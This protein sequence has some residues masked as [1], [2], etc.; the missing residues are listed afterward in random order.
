MS[1]WEAFS[2][3]ASAIEP[4]LKRTLT[5]SSTRSPLPSLNR[6]SEPRNPRFGISPSNPDR[7]AK[8]TCTD[9]NLQEVFTEKLDFTDFPLESIRFY[10]TDSVILLPSEY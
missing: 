7:T 3:V 6:S 8:L 10:F 5:G 4:I 2:C 9:G 1:Q